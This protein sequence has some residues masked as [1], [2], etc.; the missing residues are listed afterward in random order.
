[1]DSQNLGGALHGASGPAS[2]QQ[3]AAC[4]VDCLGGVPVIFLIL[5][6]DAKKSILQSKFFLMMPLG[7]DFGVDFGGFLGTKIEPS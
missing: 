3:T 1:M 5:L 2:S 7:I 4:L 6:S